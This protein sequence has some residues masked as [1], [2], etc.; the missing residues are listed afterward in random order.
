MRDYYYCVRP[1]GYIT[2]YPGYGGS[3]T[4]EPFE[5]T[6]STRLP[7]GPSRQRSFPL[8][9]GRDETAIRIS[10]LRMSRKI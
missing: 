5:Q 10:H 8:L 3:T 6:P 2:T 4:T 9:I 7:Q 1:V